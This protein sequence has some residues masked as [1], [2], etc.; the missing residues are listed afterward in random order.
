[1]PD[2]YNTDIIFSNALATAAHE[3]FEGCC[4]KLYSI[5]IETSKNDISNEMT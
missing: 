5:L 2:N 1:M 4:M 3:Y